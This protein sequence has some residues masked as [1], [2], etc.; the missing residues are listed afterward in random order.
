MKIYLKT[1]IFLS[2]IEC[3]TQKVTDEVCYCHNLFFEVL[4][5]LFYAA[6]VFEGCKI[7]L[8]KSILKYSKM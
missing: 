1:M 4:L 8:M 7:I 2:L 6:L 5:D 3:Y